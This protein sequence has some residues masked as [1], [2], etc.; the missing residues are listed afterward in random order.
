MAML[1]DDRVA[2][3][4][5]RLIEI[6]PQQT[7]AVR[8]QIPMAELKMRALLDNH[9]LTLFEYAS[10]R[11]IVV[12]GPLF[13][14]S[15][16]FG[17]ERADIEIGLPVAEQPLALAKLAGLPP[18]NIGSSSLP[19]GAVAMIIHRGP[20]KA[21]GEAHQ[22]LQEWIR[23]EGYQEAPGPWDSYVDDPNK[24]DKDQVRTEI[25]WPIA[26]VPER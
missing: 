7:I 5:P 20:Y 1:Y 9:R 13:S 17:P 26:S 16:E 21:L 14:R 8:V 19:G 18:G 23:G 22:H 11:G 25:Y 2:L 10:S 12:N 15:H 6:D 24:V 3:A 4:D